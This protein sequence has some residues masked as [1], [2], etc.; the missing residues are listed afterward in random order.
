MHKKWA[1]TL[2]ILINKTNSYLSTEHKKAL[3]I[4]TNCL[5]TKNSNKFKSQCMN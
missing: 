4:Q 2:N 5:Q 1:K 3:N